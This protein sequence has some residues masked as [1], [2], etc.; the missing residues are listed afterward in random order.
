MSFDL[1]NLSPKDLDALIAGA[2]ERK[3]ALK[4]RKPIAVVREKLAKAAVKEGY[5]LDE[6]FAGTK[7]ATVNT[8]KRASKGVAKKAS[9]RGRRASAAVAAD[10][11][12]TAS[13]RAAK[14]GRGRP[15]GTG[16]GGKVAPK[17]RNP[18]NPEEVW[19]GRGMAPRWMKA[20]LDQ[21][22]SKDN[23]LI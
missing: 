16:A 8:A 21:G 2:R 15:A 4:K 3:S 13:K 7:T 11:A 12:P 20:Y 10:A 19:S 22:Q 18:A 9:K 1:S 17:Y 23:F 6:L 5:S 14:R